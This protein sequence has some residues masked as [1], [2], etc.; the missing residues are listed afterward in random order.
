MTNVTAG[1][2]MG[3]MPGPAPAVSL[4]EPRG[5]DGAPRRASVVLIGQAPGAPDEP[6]GPPG[7][8]I[9]GRSLKRLVELARVPVSTFLMLF[10][11]ANLLSYYPGPAEGG[12]GHAF[13]QAEGRAA[14]EALAP[15]LAGRRAIFLGKNVASCMRVPGTPWFQWHELKVP[16]GAAARVCTM[17]HPSGA[18][19]WWN[20]PDN[21]DLASAFLGTV[22]ED[23]ARE[24]SG[25]LR[26][27]RS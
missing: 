21:R 9:Q 5:P 8:P 2:D 27:R 13:D 4:V 6:G 11:R 19:D 22:A 10:A 7:E 23:L 25:E 16:G 20:D 17:P 12:R 14:A 15:H 26:A 1:A 3:T 18:S 24:L